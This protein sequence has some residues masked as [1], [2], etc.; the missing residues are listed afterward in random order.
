MSEPNQLVVC[1]SHAP[2]IG[3]PG[4]EDAGQE[5]RSG[6]RQ[7]AALVREFDPELIICFGTDHRRAF[8]N[9][10][11]TFGVI[12]DA[13]GIVG[14]GGSRG[15][16][17]DIPQD[18]AKD[19]SEWLIKGGVDAAV[20]VG[21]R[22]DH[23][24]AQPVELLFGSLDAL[25]IVPIFINTATPPLPGVERV[26]QL[27]ESVGEFLAERADRRVL[28][29]ASGGLSHDPPTLH[30]P[31]RILSDEERGEY[32]RAGAD[33]ARDWVVPDWD[34][35]FLR[36]FSKEGGDPVGFLTP[37]NLRRAGNGAHEVRTWI[38]AWHCAGRPPLSTLV[39]QPM[40][41]WITGMG[42]VA[43]T[44]AVERWQ[45]VLAGAEAVR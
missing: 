43:S 14:D 4:Q 6:L 26:A 33:A 5:F 10:I 36:A 37:E 39:Y 44:W 29:V 19:L 16:K 2:F 23:G 20:S 21:L 13:E 34:R 42:I 12:W 17:L 3:R 15:G 28:T 27:G 41:E 40:R 35:E 1:A 9:T 32:G 18:V 22:L 38:A 45:S 30:A 8:Q 7:A 31:S 24:F 11:P 25:P